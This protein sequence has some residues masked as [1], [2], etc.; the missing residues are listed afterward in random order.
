MKQSRRVG[1]CT[2]ESTY[3]VKNGFFVKT[4]ERWAKV[5]SAVRYW[6]LSSAH[7]GHIRQGKAAVTLRHEKAARESS[8][9][10]SRA[11]S[12]RLAM[13]TGCEGYSRITL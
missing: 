8:H 12:L 1:I 2:S 3:I 10:D 7:G 13:V 9:E 6:R 11:A 4:D 5:K